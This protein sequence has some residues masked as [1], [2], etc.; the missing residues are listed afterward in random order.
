MLAKPGSDLKRKR[1]NKEHMHAPFENASAGI[2]PDARGSHLV[3]RNAELSNHTEHGALTI[4][5]FPPLSTA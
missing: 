1:K 2:G 5:S 4:S 3:Y